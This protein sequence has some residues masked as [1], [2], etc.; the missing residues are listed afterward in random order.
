MLPDFCLEKEVA[1]I[2]NSDEEAITSSIYPAFF[3]SKDL[4]TLNKQ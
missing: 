1:L 2:T 4:T 3:I